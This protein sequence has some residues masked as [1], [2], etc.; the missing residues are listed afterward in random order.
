MIDLR[1]ELRDSP[2]MLILRGIEPGRALAI[3]RR[4]WTAGVGLVEVPLQSEQDAEVLEMLVQASADLGRAV[5][6]GTVVTT[7]IAARARHA[8]AQ[9]TVAPGVDLD[10]LEASHRWGMAHLP[11]VGSGSDIQQAVRLG[12]SIVKVFPAAAL[13]A[14]WVRAM[15]G[16]FPD[17]GMVATGG[18]SSQNARAF[19]DAG[20]DAVAVGS[21]LE[22]PEELVTLTELLSL[23]SRPETGRNIR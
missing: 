8:G 19:L 2:L 18:M 20:A 12:C 17:I 3:A 1:S 15:R 4:A 11:G 13:G 22:D 16:P 10:V 7:D 23:R 5:G 9:F 14:S 21:A 6:A